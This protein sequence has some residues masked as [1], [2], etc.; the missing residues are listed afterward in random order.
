[1]G[2]T[3]CCIR[4]IKDAPERRKISHPHRGW[5]T[6]TLTCEEW[7]SELRHYKET[8]PAL[9]SSLRRSPRSLHSGIGFR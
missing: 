4:Q 3:A 1:M 8:A 2:V 6:A 7:L 5:G 9:R